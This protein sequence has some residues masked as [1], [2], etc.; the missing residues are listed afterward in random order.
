MHGKEVVQ[1]SINLCL[2]FTDKMLSQKHNDSTW[3]HPSQLIPT[4]FSNSKVLCTVC[5]Q[6]P[7]ACAVNEGWSATLN[8]MQLHI[9]NQ[10]SWSLNDFVFLSVARQWCRIILIIKSLHITP[11]P[12][13][14]PRKWFDYTVCDIKPIVP[15][16]VWQHLKI[17]LVTG[18][19]SLM[20]EQSTNHISLI[21]QT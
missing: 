18:L 15:F 12:R 10:Q 2:R 14:S 1:V 3:P 19:P 11:P 17:P 5:L 8:C 13:K 16:C 9:A 20:N 4:D 6:L 21:K 7:H